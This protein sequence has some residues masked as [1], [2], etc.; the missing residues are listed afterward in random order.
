MILQI[1]TE[2]ELLDMVTKIRE[3]L[4][5]CQKQNKWLLKKMDKMQGQID[6][7]PNT[8]IKE[9]VVKEVEKPTFTEVKTIEL[10]K[11]FL[12][13]IKKLSDRIAEVEKA[14]PIITKITQGLSGSDV[15]DI[16]NKHVTIGFVNKLYKKGK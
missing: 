15:S 11:S 13:A 4:T 1:K 12:P 10:D 3:D 2:Q 9:T 16:I 7:K 5:N 14:K 6:E 8:V